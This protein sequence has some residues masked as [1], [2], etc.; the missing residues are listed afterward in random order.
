MEV[1]LNPF[2]KCIKYTAFS[3]ANYENRN[4]ISGVFCSVSQ[5]N[6][7]MAATDGNRLTRIIEKITNQSFILI[8]ITRYY[9]I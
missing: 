1:E 5:E 9:N 6:L 3:A 2:I 7:E 4:I 8:R